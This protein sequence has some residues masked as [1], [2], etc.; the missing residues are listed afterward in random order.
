MISRG[1]NKLHE[2]SQKR[3]TLI[4]A[5]FE[6]R[7]IL[8]L[9]GSETDQRPV[10]DHSEYFDF[11]N[12]DDSVRQQDN[13]GLLAFFSEQRCDDVAGVLAIF[14]VDARQLPRRCLLF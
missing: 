5:L 12:T 8:R 2:R 10:G 14:A 13:I 7:R 3:V 1:A 11:G 9:R 6:H 4:V